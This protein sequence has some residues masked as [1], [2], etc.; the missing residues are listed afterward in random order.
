MYCP[1]CG[2]AVA[3]GLSYCNYC[4]AK[5]SSGENVSKVPEVKPDFLVAAMVGLFIFGLVAITM[6]MGVMKVI[7]GLT[8][9]TVLV[10]T[11]LPL[12]LLLAI[13]GVLLRLLF[14]D[15]RRSERTREELSSKHSTNQLDPAQARVLPEP[16][17]SVT[18]HTTR[19]F[20]PIYKE[21][22]SK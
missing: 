4:G 14:R 5:L 22:T 13:E 16:A 21:R 15:R 19:A 20:D 18:E 8:V 1:T 2:V 6:L 10:F 11:L 3:P 12:L 7:L 9:E 17:T